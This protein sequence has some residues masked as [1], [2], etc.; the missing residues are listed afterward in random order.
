MQLTHSLTPCA[1]ELAALKLMW[2]K[3]ELEGRRIVCVWPMPK[4]HSSRPTGTRT[5]QYEFDMNYF[6]IFD[7]R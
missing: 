7:M 5:V 3:E 1:E 4:L 6:L 2:S